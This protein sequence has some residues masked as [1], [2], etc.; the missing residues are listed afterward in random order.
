MVVDHLSGWVVGAGKERKEK[1]L[2]RFFRKLGPQRAAALEAVSMDMLEPY[3]TVVAWVTWD[4]A[5]VDSKE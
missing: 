2:L 4:S 3:L 1:T 5:T